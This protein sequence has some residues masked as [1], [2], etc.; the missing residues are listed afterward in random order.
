ML[1]KVEA[2]SR[3]G[4]HQ[5]TLVRWAEYGILQR[6]AYNA[7]AYLYELSDNLPTK[8]C[9]RW[10]TLVDRVAALKMAKESKP[11]D[12]IERGVV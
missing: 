10:D 1:T 2:A 6:H 12:P 8:H 11:S 4:I 5:L 7:H 3:L 9:S